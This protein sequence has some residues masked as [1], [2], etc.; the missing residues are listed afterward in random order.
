MVILLA[1]L[2]PADSPEHSA[3]RPIVA[4]WQKSSGR[5][6]AFNHTGPQT[7]WLIMCENGARVSPGISRYCITPLEVVEGDVLSSPARV[8]PREGFPVERG[9]W[10]EGRLSWNWSWYLWDIHIYTAFFQWQS[11]RHNTE[12]ITWMVIVFP[13]K[14]F[15][16]VGGWGLCGH[17]TLGFMFGSVSKCDATSNNVWESCVLKLISI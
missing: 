12:T 5:P 1:G 11:V 13:F 9:E 6:L 17:L 4:E 10:G 14:T 7:R 15:F 8:P 3:C 2:D 16:F